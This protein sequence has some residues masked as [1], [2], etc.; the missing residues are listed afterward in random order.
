MQVINKKVSFVGRGKPKYVEITTDKLYHLATEAGINF[1]TSV[2]LGI[3][4]SN[5]HTIIA[6][7]I[8]FEA[9]SFICT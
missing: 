5:H 1:R 7:V 3:Y 8:P 2:V 9:L 6:I 4:N